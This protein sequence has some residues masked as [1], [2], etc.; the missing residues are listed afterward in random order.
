MT[1]RPHLTII[2]ALLLAAA[3][4]ACAGESGDQQADTQAVE[5]GSPVAI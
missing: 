1:T 2:S 5:A 4:T 3:L